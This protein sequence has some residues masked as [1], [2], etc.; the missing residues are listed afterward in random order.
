[1][2]YT[3]RI[4]G[5]AGQG[6]QSVGG[7]LA[8]VFARSGFHVFTH[9]D[10][11]SRIRGGHN[12]YQ[13]RFS[14]DAVRASRGKVDILVALDHNTI[15][16]H[17][18]LLSHRGMVVYDG[19][20]I[21]RA[22]DNPAYLN[23]PF[24]RIAR[25]KGGSKIMSN[26]VATGA[27]LG[28][29]GADIALY[30]GIIR[31]TFKKKGQQIVVA[32][33]ASA[34]AGFD[35][36]VSQCLRCNFTVPS[37]GA[38]PLMLIDGNEAIGLG[39]LMSGCRFYAAYP[40]TPSTGI[41]IFLASKASDHG[42][43]VEQAEDEIAAINMALG[44]SFAGVRA[45]TGSSG[46]GFA[47]MAEGLSL[48]AMTETPIVIAVAQRPGPATGLPTRTEQADLLFVLH[49]GHGE[50]PRAVFAPGT[51][52]QAFYLTNKAFDLAEKYQIPAFILSDQYLADSQW[53]FKALDESRIKYTDYRV[54]S[55]GLEALYRYRR[56]ALT[57]TGVSP[58]GIPGESRHLVVT[59]SD[60]HDEDG[61]IIED[62][63]TRVQMVRKRVLNKLPFIQ[64]EIDPPEFYGDSNPE[65]VLA[66]WGS[67]Y[68]PMREVVDLLSREYPVAMLHFSELYP[69]PKDKPF[70]YERIL[71]RAR[72]SICVENNATGQFARLLQ[73]E[74]GFRFHDRI[75][76]YDGRPF[77]VEAL[78]EEILGSIRRL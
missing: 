51:P 59:D 6:L 19:E 68:G 73:G 24:E 18:S 55:G 29:I 8:R 13:V 37:K 2:D 20:A 45:M 62:A 54:R 25:E 43:V 36:A 9:Q 22:Y 23:V 46:G 64:E 67:T 78:Q 11:M 74:I 26:T 69:F 7:A 72:L 52:E 15:E 41:M 60:E 44:A 1:M 53:T 77:L 50:F 21:G 48:A 16:I 70:E 47:L 65:I 66:G 27:V 49:A 39:A 3:I 57:E 38:T 34:K 71:D 14:K 4:G 40:M 75:V 56:H 32:N 35:Y 61:H 17:A 5:E 30:E 12:F 33:L 28:M 76:K 10:Y 63:E 42:I 58:L 31:E